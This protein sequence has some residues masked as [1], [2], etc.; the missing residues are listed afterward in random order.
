MIEFDLRREL[1]AVAR[2]YRRLWLW[3]RLALCWLVF[4]LLGLAALAMARN[5]DRLPGWITPTLVASA[6]IA[7]VFCIWTA[8][9][10]VRDQIWLARRLE[11]QFPDLDSRLLTALEQWRT[12]P[13][14]QL[15][16]LQHTVVAEALAHARKRDWQ[17]VV[18][19][20]SLSRARFAHLTTLFALAIVTG[21]LIVET[22]ARS[23]LLSPTGNVE[24]DPD[25][26]I[27]IRVEPGNTSIERGTSLLVLAHF[28]GRLPGEVSLLARPEAERLQAL[29]MSKSLDDPVFA[30]R[31]PSVEQDLTYC[32]RYDNAQTEWY[33]VGVF[34]FPDLIQADARLEFPSYTGMP[35]AIVDDTRSVSA[36]QGTK[37]TLICRLNKLVAAATLLPSDEK[38]ALDKAVSAKGLALTADPADQSVFSLTLDLQSSFRCRVHLVDHDGRRNKQPPE[39]VIN[40]LPNRPPEVKAI[41]PARDVQASPLEELSL[42]ARLW[43]DFGIHR[44]GVSYS[45]AG[46]P[47]TEATLGEKAPA[48]ERR[49]SV[50]VLALESLAA[51]PDH[52]LSYYFWAEDHA[53]DGSVRRT[54]GDMFFAEIRPFEEIFRQGEQP[55]ASEQM[56]QQGSQNAQ[57]AEQ[58]AELQKQI[59]NA[60][61]KLIRREILTRPSAKFAADV[62]LISESQASAKE[63]AAA[64]GEQLQDPRSKAYLDSALKQMDLALEELKKAG[65]TPAIDRL[66]PALVA[67]Q[68]AYQGLLRLRAREHEVIRGNRQ[69]RGGGG[70]GGGGNR[71]QQQLNQLE[72]SQ[73]ENRYESEHAASQQ[74]TQ[75]QAQDRETRQ[76][77]NRLRELAQRQEDLNQQMKELQ[78]ALRE[79]KDEQEREELRRQLARLRDQQQEQLRDTDELRDRMDNAE[80]QERMAEG[81]QQ[82]D[83]TRSNIR[84]AS[85]ALE[86]GIVSQAAAAGARASEEL[87]QLRDQFR[88]SAAGQ[89]TESMR[90]MRDDARKLDQNQQ[91]LSKRLS[92]L[93][94]SDQRTLRDSGERGQVAQDLA[95]QKQELDKLLESMRQTVETAENT[96]PLLSKQL[97]DQVRETRQQNTDKALDASRQLL[98]RGFLRESRTVEEEAR[99]GITNLR[100]GVEQA[101]Q[102]VLGNEAEALRRARDELDELA[103]ELNREI[104]RSRGNPGEQDGN[105]SNNQGQP[106]NPSAT[107]GDSQ[108]GDRQPDADSQPTGS[109]QSPG[110][111]QQQGDRQGNGQKGDGQKQDGQSQGDSSQRG[112]QQTGEPQQGQSQ[113]GQSKQGGSPQA[114]SQQGQ[115]GGNRDGQRDQN[116]QQQAGSPD[117]QNG[118]RD[119]EGN[120]SDRNGLNRNGGDRNSGDLRRFLDGGTGPGGNEEFGPLTGD[121]FREWSDR[122]RDVEEM[123]S[124]S[125]LRGQAARIRDRARAMRSEFK[126]HSKEP[127]WE[128]VQ[129]FIGRPLVELRNAVNEE[130]LR[131]ESSDKLVPIDREP[132]PPE[133]VEQ[134]R[135]YYERLGSGQ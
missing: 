62:N 20:R 126:R 56:Q 95:R 46:Q 65:E 67:E 111:Q 32:V 5:A 112:S 30:G 113:Q 98:E 72:L 6:V 55:T 94:Q 74:N 88:Q 131:R 59:I 42:K 91:D 73:S 22:Q 114:S 63:Q 66:Q 84:R 61:W 96:E 77:L 11:H 37:L 23:R 47:L 83:E 129:E 99:R 127:N 120:N 104:A 4:T 69:Q 130:L 13:D 53:P 118:Q 52:L 90:Q 108:R 41:A 123:V 14:D 92:E 116:G 29:A 36:V 76:V 31:V 57:R 9:R 86:Q 17:G 3:Q 58:L 81:R 78:A 48:K 71:S 34:D 10:G 19:D 28:D 128:L 25:A 68:S 100:E 18:S 89:F 133:F 102:S 26:P 21:L 119:G 51:E 38:L 80:N 1:E 24:A 105:N 93:G 115:G 109:Q 110:Q 79:A 85:E 7:A 35:T 125:D 43:D 64:L 15:G 60:T 132:V 117:R 75:Q 107:N 50:H 54:A 134:V 27:S 82:L 135:R 45:L 40:V 49:E 2:R 124:D 87:N 16:F 103:E 70:G 33:R 122:L 121:S 97:Y 101:A 8:R 12:S 106:P 39:F 44:Y